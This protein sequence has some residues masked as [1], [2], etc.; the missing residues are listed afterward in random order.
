MD[1]YSLSIEGWIILLCLL[2]SAI[3]LV[4]KM[5]RSHMNPTCSTCSIVGSNFISSFANLRPDK[6]NL[7][8]IMFDL[9]NGEATT[10]RDKAEEKIL[11]RY[12]KIQHSQNRAQIIRSFQL[13]AMSSQ[14]SG[15]HR[16][17]Q[18]SSLTM[19]YEAHMLNRAQ[20]S[21]RAAKVA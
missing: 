3:I 10:N 5:K 21:A 13:A 11:K 17:G 1:L 8:N 9:G 2:P 20:N 15:C 7:N 4:K 6:N 12:F 16:L 14:E 19:I 18:W